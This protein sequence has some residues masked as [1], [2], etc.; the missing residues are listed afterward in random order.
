MRLILTAIVFTAT[1]SLIFIYEN[2]KM[3]GLSVN[4][5]NQD[6]AA[7]L[8]TPQVKLRITLT[9]SHSPIPLPRITAVPYPVTPTLNPSSPP[10]I[11]TLSP[12]P[13]QSKPIL[14]TPIPTI[15]PTLIPVT[16]EII[17]QPTFQPSE[18]ETQIPI[19]VL[20]LT[21]PIKRGKEAKLDIKTELSSC[22]LEVVLPSG[23]ISGA[24]GLQGNKIPDSN[25][26]ISWQWRIGGST[27]AGTANLTISCLANSK[28]INVTL[29]MVITE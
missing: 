4:T 2:K 5:K 29:Q 25:S 14:T 8:K 6:L 26:I 9:P 18:T 1:I 20:S 22:K 27:K 17:P 13:I 21:S 16:P 11:I 10:V 19:N 28:T 15:P 23:A 7:I 12:T 24:S 3:A